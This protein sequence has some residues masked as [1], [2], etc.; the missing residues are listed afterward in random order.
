VHGMV[1]GM[2]LSNDVAKLPQV[3]APSAHFVDNVDT[4]H[5]DVSSAAK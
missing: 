3:E 1:H 4:G 5:V 2:V